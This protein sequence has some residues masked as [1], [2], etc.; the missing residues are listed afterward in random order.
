MTQGYEAGHSGR[1]L[2]AILKQE[3][4]SRGFLFR[5]HRDDKNNLDMFNRRVVLRH[6]PYRSIYGSV[7]RSEFLIIDD[8]RRIRIEC[9]WQ[10]VS[11]SVDEK[12]PY[13]LQNAAER[14]PESHV[15]LFIGG[16][17]AKRAAVLW[18]KREAAA[19]RHKRIDV[20]TVDDFPRWVRNELVRPNTSSTRD[21]VAE[22]GASVL[23][24]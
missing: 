24:F 17:G 12:F 18:L 11:G 3:L 21:A 1:F 23:R 4:E 5:K 22:P 9:R 6:A 10:E 2:E 16:K 7:S 8:A 19:I 13:L 15:V 14:M 20:I